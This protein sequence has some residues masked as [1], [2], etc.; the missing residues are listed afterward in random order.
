[1]PVAQAD[2]NRTRLQND[3]CD[4]T[5]DQVS[6]AVRRCGLGCHAERLCC[7]SITLALVR[8]SIAVAIVRVNVPIDDRLAD[9]I[10]DDQF[11]IRPGYARDRPDLGF[12]VLQDGLRD[13]ISV[14]DA[15]LVGVAGAHGIRLRLAPVLPY[16]NL[17]V[18]REFIGRQ[19]KVIRRRTLP[20]AAR[21]IVDRAVTRAKVTTLIGAVVTDRHAAEMRANTDHDQPFWL[22][23]PRFIGGRIGQL[24]DGD[25]A[26]FFDLFWS[27]M[28]D[29]D[30]LAPTSR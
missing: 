8:P 6:A 22:L 2:F 24:T 27:T 19:C 26:C 4:V 15:L 13:V 16:R 23:H 7:R 5:P 10:D 28:A 3:A 17:C 9:R 14:S 11:D 21:A 25:R 12:S 29:E 20:D 1:M 18:A 30:W